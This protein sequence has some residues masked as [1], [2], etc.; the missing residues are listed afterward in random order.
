VKHARDA[1]LDSI[2]PVLIELR[3]LDDVR[4]KNRGVFY[5]KSI[6]FIH[7]H[8]DPA[9]IFADMRRAGEW[10]RLPVNTAADRRRLLRLAKESSHRRA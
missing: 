10:L 4:E 3:Q 8:E 6:A 2:E 7:F 1:A 5:K 9:G